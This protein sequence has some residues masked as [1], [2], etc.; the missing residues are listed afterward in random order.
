MEKKAKKPEHHG[1]DAV[2]ED[3][4]ADD[5]DL[6][7]LNPAWYC[8]T[9][10]D[11]MTTLERDFA[12]MVGTESE[13]RERIRQN[14]SLPRRAHGKTSPTRPVETMSSGTCDTAEPPATDGTDTGAEGSGNR[15]DRFD[16]G[17]KATELGRRATDP[18]E[19]ESDDSGSEEPAAT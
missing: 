12:T 14:A 9:L 17:A 7:G 11:E 15:H 5:V 2:A 6:D 3:D 19:C 8:K 18:E 1:A 13:T 4:S 16:E 10:V